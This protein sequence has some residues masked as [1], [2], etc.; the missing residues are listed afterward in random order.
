MSCYAALPSPF[1]FPYHRTLKN[2]RHF[3]GYIYKQGK[4]RQKKSNFC[5]FIL[6][7]TKSRAWKF[8]ITHMYIFPLHFWQDFFFPKW[9]FKKK[10]LSFST[11]FL[12]IPWLRPLDLL[13]IFKLS[14]IFNPKLPY[15][16]HANGSVKNYWI[17]VSR[18]NGRVCTDTVFKPQPV[19]TYDSI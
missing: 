2:H 1:G 10:N 14:T 3:P 4:E 18:W 15:Y 19:Q 11:L 5:S 8:K 7:R 12:Y 6:W 17:Y 16:H 13:K 9:E